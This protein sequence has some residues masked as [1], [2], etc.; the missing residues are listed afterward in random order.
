MLNRRI[1]NSY[2]DKLRE[3]LL[4]HHNNMK[5]EDF[6]FYDVVD[7]ALADGV[8]EPL[9]I[10]CPTYNNESPEDSA[11]FSLALE[12][13]RNYHNELIN[14]LIPAAESTYTTYGESP[15]PEDMKATRDHRAFGGFSM[16]SR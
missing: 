16:G 2:V 14:D 4:E 5:I 6:E 3:D 8:F 7:N 11:N 12:L 1:W 13:N 10:V 15:L 9:I